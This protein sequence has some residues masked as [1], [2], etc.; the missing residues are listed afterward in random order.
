MSTLDLRCP[1]GCDDGRFEALNTPLIVDASGRYI[2]HRAEGATYVCARCQCVAVDLGGAA[3]EMRRG[4]ES[5]VLTLNC[6]ACGLSML[7]PEDEPL[8]SLLE[9]PACETRF[10][11]DEAMTRLHS[12][13]GSS[14]GSGW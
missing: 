1:S 11:I 9:C 14:A 8:A 5:S 2:E 6:P 3:R 13:G 4:E 12:A 7:P 10:Q